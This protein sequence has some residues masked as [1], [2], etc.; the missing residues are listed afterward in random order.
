MN[1]KVYNLPS[2]FWPYLVAAK[3]IGFTSS[4]A[5]VWMLHFGDATTYG[6]AGLFWASLFVMAAINICLFRFT[7]PTPE[8]HE[9]LFLISLAVDIVTASYL[10]LP[11]PQMI[12][13]YLIALM[14]I[15]S[16]YNFVLPRSTGTVLT[17]LSI[18]IYGF[19]IML[20]RV[21]GD[22]DIFR[23]NLEA[24]AYC[25]I[26]L[27]AM[28][29]S[30]LLVRKIKRNIDEIYQVSEDLVTDLSMQA[31]S[32]DLAVES[33]VERNREV[34]TLLQILEN[35]ISVL[36]WEELF[37]KIVEALRNRFDFDKFS[38]YIYNQDE[39]R[40]ELKVESG[41]E[42][43]TGVA[44]SVKLDQG[45]V[46]WSF[47]NR[48][49]VLIDDVLED[50]R[51]ESFNQRGKK[52]RSLACMPLMF[53]QEALGVLCLDSHRTKS[54]DADAFAFLQSIAP[55]ISIAV[56]NSLNY[57]TV[58]TE[59]HTDNLT[60]LN[61][62]GGFMEKFIP[63]LN[64]AYCKDIPLGLIYM[65]IDH[66]KSINDTYGHLVGNLVIQ[67]LSQIL[68]TFF[69]GTDLVGRWGGEE[70]AVV[71]KG[72]PPEI[73][74]R[75]AEQ[76]RRKVEAHQFPISLQRDAFKQVTISIGLATTA[77]TNLKPEVSRG[78]R[79]TGEGDVFL[80]NVEEI[81]ALF[82]DNADHALYTAKNSGRNQVMLSKFFP[83][84][85]NES[86][87]IEIRS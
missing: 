86:R 24:G 79:S 17:G 7:V 18:L 19:S 84:P 8:N 72:T 58:K 10:F 1:Q 34:Q 43:A 48:E 33:L 85:Q 87:T 14:V 6:S 81:S 62:H 22:L 67:E 9:R 37:G 78:S 46:G 2:R 38:I 13:I 16:F 63:M 39:Q 29:T 26:G 52:I 56:S 73:A 47:T 74:P 77:D 55:L 83:I 64:E 32:A 35:I 65:D 60:Q 20:A 70:F 41:D 23:T 4:Y 68:K 36:D 59:S 80:K 3:L 21:N 44:R 66:F 51:W 45:V 53:R 75:I 76:L 50:K 25:L 71:L 40:L 28:A 11:Q 54:F 5:F 42:A 30:T 69:R 31:I 82:V 61:N 27:G 12:L 57:T 15:N 49:G